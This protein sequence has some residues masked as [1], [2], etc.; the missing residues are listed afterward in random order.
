MQTSRHTDK[1]KIEQRDS[2]S[3]MQPAGMQTDR[4]A[5]NQTGHDMAGPDRTE[6]DSTGQD[7]AESR[8]GRQI[9]LPWN[10]YQSDITLLKII[11]FPSKFQHC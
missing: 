5:D 2:D 4:Q 1:Q 10:S 7:W 11:I 8:T 9:T 3:H 6:P